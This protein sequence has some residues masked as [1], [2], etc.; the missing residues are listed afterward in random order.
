MNCISILAHQAIARLAKVGRD[1]TGV[2]WFLFE[3]ECTKFI[4]IP[5]VAGETRKLAAGMEVT[6]GGLG[7]IRPVYS[8]DLADCGISRHF[9]ERS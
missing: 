9:V 6:E 2:E 5:P 1:V 3:Y 8:E 7:E 4:Y